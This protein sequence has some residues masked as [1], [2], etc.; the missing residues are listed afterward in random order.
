MITIILNGDNKQLDSG[1]SIAQLLETLDLSEK[2]LAV[3]INQQI[4]ARSDF[5]NF[6]LS[7]QDK[8]EIVQAIG[9]GCPDLTQVNRKHI[10]MAAP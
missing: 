2:R 9:G 3:E 10:Y 1:T 5:S 7:D 6:T 4:I 8:V